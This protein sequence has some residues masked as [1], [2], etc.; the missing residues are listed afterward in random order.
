MAAYGGRRRG[1]RE[2]AALVGVS[3]TE[4]R[5]KGRDTAGGGFMPLSLVSALPNGGTP[6]C[7]RSS[8][9][10]GRSRWCQHYRM[11]GALHRLRPRRVTAALVG[12]SITE[13]RPRG[14][15]MVLGDDEPLS[16]VSALPNGGP[17]SLR[18]CCCTP[19]AL[20]GVSITEWRSTVVRELA[21]ALKP[22]S[23]VSALPNGGN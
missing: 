4:W 14:D 16:L 18:W 21:D 19:A 6:L 1:R 10:R 9:G 11:A 23:L 22:L 8:A 5:L 2:S 15:G 12:V 7:G 3:I 20:V 17:S 13:W